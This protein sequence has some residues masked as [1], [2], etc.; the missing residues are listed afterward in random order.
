MTPELPQPDFLRPVARPGRLAWAWCGTGLL[1]LAV[2]ATDGHAAWQ[3]RQQAQHR[4]AVAAP[5][6]PGP[7]ASS[8][9]A[10]RAAV[11]AG[12]N[13]AQAREAEAARWLGL[14]AQ[15]WAAVWAASESG[16]D[17]IQ[18]LLFDHGAGGLR[19]TGVAAD[20]APAEAAAETLR[21]QALAGTA[22]WQG[23]T[24]SAVERVTDGQRFELVA[25]LAV[26]PV[27]GAGPAAEP[28]AAGGSRTAR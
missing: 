27:P 2:S 26:P 21:R 14:L 6:A 17:G 3:A 16:V 24:L 13:P 10:A 9:S 18:W 20:M 8:G 1:V 12:R 23:V 7:A 11:P 4:L 22:A 5:V 25:R 15:P 28:A 19:L